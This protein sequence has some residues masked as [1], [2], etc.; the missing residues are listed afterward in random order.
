MNTKLAVLLGALGVALT[1][2]A[3]SYSIA[4]NYEPNALTETHAE[5]YKKIKK[6]QTI[7]TITD[8]IYNEYNTLEIDINSKPLRLYGN[9]LT[10]VNQYYGAITYYV[11]FNYNINIQYENEE[12]NIF[13]YT[14]KINSI[15]LTANDPANDYYYNYAAIFNSNNTYT[16]YTNTIDAPNT[17]SLY[18]ILNYEI[19]LDID[20]YTGIGFKDF[21]FCYNDTHQSPEEQV[22]SQNW[23]NPYTNQVWEWFE[24]GTGPIDNKPTNFPHDAEEG[25]YYIN[26]LYFN[27]GRFNYKKY[28][29]IIT[30]AATTILYN[31]NN[32]N[33]YTEQQYTTNY[34]T[35]YNNGLDTGLQT[36]LTNPNQYN[37]YTGEQLA[38][39]AEN[40]NAEIID[41]PGMMLHVLS[42]PWTFISNAFDL[43]IFE[44]TPYQIN[45]ANI[46]KGLIA[47]LALMFIIKMFTNGFSALG[48][49]ASSAEDR[50]NKKAD[51]NL[52]KSQAKLNDAKTSKIESKG[53]KEKK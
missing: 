20:I 29:E 1:I 19:R 2:S 48:N 42:M 24:K 33:L 52:K 37:L 45:F 11:A 27:L 53:K 38:A 21:Y 16:L 18:D 41:L 50:K 43:T 3:C 5:D 9:N 23:I 10:T 49:V 15:Y 51:T 28:K 8:Q 4:S 14:L 7:Q 40:A 32:Y 6:G 46:F 30:N 22:I 13:T 36:V 47:I 12:E 26:N 35:G 44:G 31:P 39:V 25:T 17:Q 34:T